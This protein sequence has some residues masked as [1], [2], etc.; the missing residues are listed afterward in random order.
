MVWNNF[1][2]HPALLNWK[3][4]RNTEERKIAPW[5]LLAPLPFLTTKAVCR[6]FCL[7]FLKCVL[8][9]EG[10]FFCHQMGKRCKIPCHPALLV[11]G[12]TASF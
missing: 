2:G 1:R 10:R 12:G 6:A 5:W 8:K 7:S 9:E 3:Q 4:K 11:N